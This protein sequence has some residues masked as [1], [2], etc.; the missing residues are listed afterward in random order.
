ML[1]TLPAPPPLRERRRRELTRTI[2]NAALDLFERDGVGATTI[3]DIAAAA[4]I[5]RTTFFRHCAG[6]EAAVL[7]DDG[8]FE[9][10]VLAA[11]RVADDP[12]RALERSWAAI[13]EAFD[14]DPEGHGRFLRVRRLTRVEPTLLAAARERA[15][16][17][18]DRIADAILEGR[19]GS[20]LDARVIAETFGLTLQLTLDEWVRQTDA[21]SGTVSLRSAHEDVVQAIARTGSGAA[22]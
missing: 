13:I 3:D 5:S 4:G 12:R 11:V 21:A 19:T 14:S 7:V 15:A 20:T 22:T 9:D 8:G 1:V 16:L 10:E 17:F 2:A 18:V 6:K